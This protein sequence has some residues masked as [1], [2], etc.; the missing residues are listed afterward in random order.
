MDFVFD[1]FNC[2]S[3]DFVM[4]NSNRFISSKNM[5]LFK[6]SWENF[7]KGHDEFFLRRKLEMLGFFFF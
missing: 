1:K 4:E 3:K 5:N 6:R 7:P 2:I